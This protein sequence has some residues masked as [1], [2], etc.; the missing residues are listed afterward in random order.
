[1]CDHRVLNYI[2]VSFLLGV[3]GASHVF[4]EVGFGEIDPAA[5]ELAEKLIKRGT[6][7]R[8]ADVSCLYISG[9]ANPAAL[10]ELEKA[11]RKL[12]QSFHT[13][14][15][16]RGV[17]DVMKSSKIFAARVLRGELSQRNDELVS[18]WTSDLD[19]LSQ[20]TSQ[21]IP[22]A[23]QTFEKSATLRRFGDGTVC[24]VVDDKS[25]S[26]F[27]S[28]V[29]V[30]LPT[31]TSMDT[32]LGSWEGMR[33]TDPIA[34]Q[35]VLRRFADPF[36]S[37]VY[38]NLVGQE[39]SSEMVFTFDVSRGYAPVS[40]SEVLTKAGEK[41]SFKMPLRH[42]YF[43][44]VDGSHPVVTALQLHVVGA[45][46]EEFQ[47]YLVEKWEPKSTKDSLAQV[48]V[49]EKFTLL[50]H[51]FG[52]VPLIKSVEAAASKIRTL[53]DLVGQN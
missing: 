38:V 50:D 17:I 3:I 6:V 52:K 31:I 41:D 12:P 7:L 22:K 36:D 14:E 20:L 49:P 1:M 11:L 30:N 16:E 18:K 39:F 10:R 4:A 53:D 48:P 13:I 5:R 9:S 24:Y 33:R 19:M 46:I 26:L 34:S 32:A 44:S 43:S 15:T 51:R 40:V 25:V 23:G 29:A 45:Q 35:K 27:P 47:L 21:D 8:N 28:L 42:F 37:L 2:I